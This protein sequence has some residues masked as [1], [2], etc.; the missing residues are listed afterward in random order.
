M[1]TPGSGCGDTSRPF[2]KRWDSGVEGE[3][4]FSVRVRVGDGVC[5]MGIAISP[6]CEKS[7]NPS[8]LVWV[9]G[10]VDVAVAVWGGRR[11]WGYCCGF[12]SPCHRGDEMPCSRGA[13]WFWVCAKRGVRVGIVGVVSCLEGER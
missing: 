13:A 10:I 9:L 1:Y 4:S 2:R 6:S 8:A 5:G 7:M 11:V 3:V 12:N